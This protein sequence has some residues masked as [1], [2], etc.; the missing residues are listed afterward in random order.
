MS[1][2]WPSAPTVEDCDDNE[3][4]M[5]GKND[6]MPSLGAVVTPQQPT[7]SDTSTTAPSGSVSSEAATNMP[8]SLSLAPE[9]KDFQSDDMPALEKVIATQQLPSQTAPPMPGSWPP[10]PTVEDCHEASVSVDGKYDDMPGL[11]DSLAQQ[12]Q[13]ASGTS[14]TAPSAPSPSNAQ[15]NANIPPPAYSFSSPLFFAS[16][17]LATGGVANASPAGQA[18]PPHLLASMLLGAI[19]TYTAP[20][21]P[22]VPSA[23]NPLASMATFVSA[24][25][26]Q[27][28]PGAAEEDEEDESGD[29]DGD[30]PALEVALQ[31][32]TPMSTL[33]SQLGIEESQD[34]DAEW[35]DV[36]DDMP[37]LEAAPPLE[38]TAPPAS[39][40]GSVS[41]PTPYQNPFTAT[42]S[43]YAQSLASALQNHQATPPVA[44]NQQAAEPQSTNEATSDADPPNGP[45]NLQPGTQGVPFPIP[46]PFPGAISFSMGTLSA[47]GSFN[48]TTAPVPF[49]PQMQES[50]NNFAAVIQEA[51]A[52]TQANGFDPSTLIPEDMEVSFTAMNNL[53]NMAHPAFAP[54]P[55][56][57]ATEFVDSLE[58]V[59]IANIPEEDM[60]CPHCWLP[61]GTTDEDDTDFVFTPDK[62]EA[63][64]NAERQEAFY[65]MPFC[66]TRPDNDPVRTPCGHIF[67]RGCLIETLE[68]VNTRCPTCRQEFRTTGGG[69]SG[70]G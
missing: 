6:D 51:M 4:P 37:S 59:D 46:S 47:D 33:I 3:M 44:N 36:D 41:N 12:P 53:F 50:F 66:T 10:A 2:A 38:T 67:G 25:H 18:L 55:P 1:N 40:S 58:R 69:P 32:E 30:M 28:H 64:A 42:I 17:N 29:E 34:K 56:F 68:R 24:L 45:G 63:P 9:V 21:Q 39:N 60:R 20:S 62:D 26:A 70:T 43:A 49:P 23:T 52:F 54:G 19:P 61:F 5:M 27:S 14:A 22:P 13:M 65:E 16:T 15:S 11:E 57:S 8:G 31:P 48:S 35:E 7:S